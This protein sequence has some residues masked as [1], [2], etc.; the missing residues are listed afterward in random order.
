M[1]EVCAALSETF[2]CGVTIFPATGYYSG[3][4]KCCAYIILNRF[5][6][7]RMKELVHECDPKAYI[8][9]TEVADVFT[10]TVQLPK[11]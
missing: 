3:D 8:T 2:G 10:N 6:I 5:Q 1:E 11:R 4:A 9:I 7:G